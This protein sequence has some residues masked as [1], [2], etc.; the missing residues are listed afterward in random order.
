[1]Y[2]PG[3]FLN[4]SFDKASTDNERCAYSLRDANGDLWSMVQIAGLVARR[5]VCRVEEGD[6][7]DRGERYGMI[8][9]GS[10]VDLYLPEGYVAAARVGET[11]LAGQSVLAV[12]AERPLARSS[13]LIRYGC[14][15]GRGTQ[16]TPQ[17]S[18]PPAQHDHHPE[19]VSG[20]SV[21]GLVRPGPF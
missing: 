3:K 4:A 15:Y 6:T 18:L 20:L 19:H 7:L 12:R 16:K 11:V 8:R 5:I 10:R 21:H 14:F 9:F 17:G 13:R 2:L 1:M